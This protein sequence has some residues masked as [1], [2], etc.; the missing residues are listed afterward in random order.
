MKL[1]TWLIKTYVIIIVLCA[2]PEHVYPQPKSAIAVQQDGKIIQAG[3]MFWSDENGN[4]NV[5]YAFGVVRFNEDGSIDRSFGKNGKVLTRISDGLEGTEEL[6][7]LA[8][9][10]DGKILVAGSAPVRTGHIGNDHGILIRY[11]S[12]GSV[13]E[14]F[15]DA[16]VVKI[17]I[18]VRDFVNC[19]AL[20]PDGKII[21]AGRTDMESGANAIFHVRYNIDGSPDESF[22]TKGKVINII[23]SGEPLHEL[24]ADAT[25]IQLQPD[26]KIVTVG[27]STV[28]QNRDALLIRQNANGSL[29]ET[30]ANSGK[31]YNKL[32]HGSAANAIKILPDNKLLVAGTFCRPAGI[33]CDVKIY[34]ARYTTDGWIDKTFGTNGFS[35]IPEDGKDHFPH[36]YA[37]YAVATLPDGK[38]VVSGEFEDNLTFLKFNQTGAFDYSI[39]KDMYRIISAKRIEYYY[40]SPLKGYSLIVLNNNKILIGGNVEASLDTDI[41]EAGF[42][43][44]RLNS[45]GAIDKTFGKNG[46]AFFPIKD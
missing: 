3:S 9:Q 28:N 40:N 1:L 12:N 18:N 6:K 45:T 42:R 36:K 44:V 30:F 37:A 8:I 39:S 5:A 4:K 13:D 33:S 43:I 34:L 24:F 29:D 14:S 19:M 2:L 38:I 32:L 20:Q 22:G 7:A 17:V 15:G 16:G 35:K 11:N 23:G 25:A 10:K 26:G 31:G 41:K 27:Y 21:I 46:F